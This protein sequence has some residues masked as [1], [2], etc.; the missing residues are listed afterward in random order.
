MTAY[1]PLFPLLYGP[2]VIRVPNLLQGNTVGCSGQGERL[3]YEFGI[4]RCLTLF[5][6]F[7]SLLNKNLSVLIENV[8]DNLVSVI[9]PFRSETQLQLESLS[10]SDLEGEETILERDL[11]SSEKGKREKIQDREI[12]SVSEWPDFV[13][14]HLL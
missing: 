13:R 6:S 2:F 8:T 9:I 3:V 1:H 10:Y 12:C 14:R 5:L 11:K 7:L 4:Q